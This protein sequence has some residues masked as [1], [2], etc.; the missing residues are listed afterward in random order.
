MSRYLPGNLFKQG[1]RKAGLD[2][3]QGGGLTPVEMNPQAATISMSRGGLLRKLSNEVAH[4]IHFHL[5]SGAWTC[6]RDRHGI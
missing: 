6:L 2:F 4:T 5:A 1:L 3:Y